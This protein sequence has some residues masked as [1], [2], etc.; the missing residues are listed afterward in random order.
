MIHARC[1]INGVPAVM[2]PPSGS[3]K[4]GRVIL[5]PRT[6]AYFTTVHI[7]RDQSYMGVCI[8]STRRCNLSVHAM[9]RVATETG[10]RCAFD[11]FRPAGRCV[12]SPR[13]T[14]TY[15]T[16]FS[17]GCSFIRGTKV[18]DAVLTVYNEQYH[19]DVEILR[20]PFL[21]V[22][23]PMYKTIP[24]KTDFRSMVEK[25]TQLGTTYKKVARLGGPMKDHIQFCLWGARAAPA[26]L[27][28]LKQDES[29]DPPAMLCV[30]M[31]R[32]SMGESSDVDYVLTFVGDNSGHTF[33]CYQHIVE[34]ESYTVLADP[35]LAII[36]YS[37]D[38]KWL[39]EE[40]S[41]YIHR[42]GDAGHTSIRFR[43]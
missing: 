18:E 37:M 5:K 4:D 11:M 21:L 25:V 19:G 20:M 22:A 12:K 30:Q 26:I 15:C 38:L 42:C 29:L 33:V 6:S 35:E 3:F 28:R 13:G 2:L 32:R 10:T 7:D 8:E 17:T 9:L 39:P 1:V 31:S 24:E 40:S 16:V 34:P 43:F 27:F 41:L 36:N 14:A 23:A